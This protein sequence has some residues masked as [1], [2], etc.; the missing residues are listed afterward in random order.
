M[1]VICLEVLSDEDEN[2]AP[3]EEEDVDAAEPLLVL[4]RALHEHA[5]R[6]TRRLRSPEWHLEPFLD[7][8]MPNASVPNIAVTH[9]DFS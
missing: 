9:R 6:R 3:E 4:G 1:G 2:D 8:R 7:A 5:Q